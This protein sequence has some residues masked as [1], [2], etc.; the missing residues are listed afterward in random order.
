MREET[1]PAWRAGFLAQVIPHL[2][3]DGREPAAN[4]AIR[5][6]EAVES[7]A[8][9]LHAL[10]AL[11]SSM[12]APWRERVLAAAREGIRALEGRVDDK[13]FTMD[14]Q[15]PATIRALAACVPE[16]EQSAWLRLAMSIAMKSPVRDGRAMGLN[17]LA[18]ALPEPLLRDAITHALTLDESVVTT[19]PRGHALRALLPSLADRGTRK[20]R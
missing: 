6:L 18:E 19:N 10:R 5:A 16:P 20:T 13:D 7:V 12:E 15:L 8:D 14:W 9:R 3:P 17:D 4:E 1:N 11:A 2:P